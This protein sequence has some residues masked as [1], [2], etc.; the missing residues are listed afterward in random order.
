M[1]TCRIIE[2]QKK[3][4]K[5]KDVILDR[6][7][8]LSDD[9][10]SLA[11]SLIGKWLMSRTGGILTGGMIIETEAYRGPDD[12]ACH[13]YGNRRT[14]RT[15]VMF[16]RGGVAYVYF[17]YGMHHLFNIVTSCEDTPHAVLVR[18]LQP[19]E[20]IERI[21]MRRKRPY[22]LTSGPGMVCQAL[23]IDRS[24]TGHLLSSDP[25]WIEDRGKIFEDSEILSTKRIGIDYAG[26]DAQLPW[27]FLL[28]KQP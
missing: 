11:K 10:V 18:A 22:N 8:Y 24:H 25:I 19:T 3:R 16:R 23:G 2:A 26:E 5:E 7:F 4:K 28:A 14:D 13:A 20:G 1:G 27:R 15:E 9:V 17:C 6:S 12:R 21:R